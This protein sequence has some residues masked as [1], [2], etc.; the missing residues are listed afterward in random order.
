M[1]ST[2]HQA[3]I[4]AHAARAATTTWSSAARASPGWRSPASWPAR[5]PAGGPRACCA[6]PLRG[7]R[8]ADLRLRG[9]DRLARGARARGLDPPDLRRAGRPHAAHD[10]ALPAAVDVLD[11]RLPGALRAARRAERRRV[12]DRDGA[13]ARAGA[14]GD[15]RDHRRTPTAARSR[16]RWSSTRSAGGG[17]S[18]ATATSRRTRRSRAASR[19]I[20]AAA[21]GE[22]EIWIDRAVVPAGYG[23]SFPAGDEVRV[24]VGLVRPALPRQGADRRARRA[25]RARRRPLPG[26]LDPAQAAR[27]RP[28]ATSSSPA[29]PPATACR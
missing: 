10:R 12:R 3:G 9:A 1:P 23:W 11:L 17:C 27:R 15:G 14:D 20:P 6:R 26:Q 28:R 5:G 21:S 18:A 24:G 29:T 2:A 4:R 16:R 22:L 25:A 19:C 13:R 8:A 7:R